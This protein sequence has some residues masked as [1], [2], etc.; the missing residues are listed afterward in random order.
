MQDNIYVIVIH[1]ET[2]RCFALDRNYS[3]IKDLTEQH[4]LDIWYS[5]NYISEWDN[6]KPLVNSQLPDWAEYIDK[7]EFHAYWYES[8]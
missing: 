4:I 8:N 2:K 1:K 3:L 7:N 5:N 6:W